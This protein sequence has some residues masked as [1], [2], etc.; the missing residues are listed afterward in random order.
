[1]QEIDLVARFIII[2]IISDYF[3]AKEVKE[4]EPMQTSE[5]IV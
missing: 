2:C 5:N 4:K 3:D 1:M